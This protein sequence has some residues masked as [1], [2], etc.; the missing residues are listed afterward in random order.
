MLICLV[1]FFVAVWA[2]H[3][4]SIF[5]NQKDPSEI[6]IDEY[7]GYLITMVWLPLS[8][9]T[10]LLGFVL[11]RLLDIFKPSL[12]G[13]IDKKS[14]GGFGIVA[15]DVIAGIIAN[16]FMQVIVTYYS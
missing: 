8:W 16:I 10:I 4:H 6:V 1:L 12:I 13:W 3:E 14:K 2:S 9:K 7:L 5:L 15:D 11:F